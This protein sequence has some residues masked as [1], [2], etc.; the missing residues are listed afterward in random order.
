MTLRSARVY[1]TNM[2]EMTVL[3]HVICYYKLGD[4]IMLFRGV[5]LA[6]EVSTSV[7]QETF[8]D[9][10]RVTS[11]PGHADFLFGRKW[12]GVARGPYM[13]PTYE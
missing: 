10:V 4:F 2:D 13:W 12:E 7:T 8:S 5:S 1:H 11:N 3:Y 6:E 9:A